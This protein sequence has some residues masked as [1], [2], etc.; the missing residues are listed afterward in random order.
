MPLWAVV[1]FHVLVE[2]TSD[3]AMNDLMR[4][5]FALESIRVD[6]GQ[7]GYDTVWLARP[8]FVLPC[9]WQPW[10]VDAVDR[11][12]FQTGSTTYPR[13]YFRSTFQ[14]N[15]YRLKIHKF[16]DS[17]EVAIV[18]RWT[19]SWMAGSRWR[20]LVRKR[21]WPRW[22][23][24]PLLGWNWNILSYVQVCSRPF[25]ATTDIACFVLVFSCTCIDHRRYNHKFVAFRIGKILAT[26]PTQRR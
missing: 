20:S 12:F 1:N 2:P 10:T 24:F 9:P 5:Y 25:E 6:E 3:Q 26:D 11:S 22:K 8:D 16:Y 7:C 18:Q 15:T 17:S 21:S 14:K 4:G 13:C 23:L 19:R